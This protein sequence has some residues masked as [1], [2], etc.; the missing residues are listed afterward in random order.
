[1]CVGNVTAK[2][3]GMA[4]KHARKRVWDTEI[5][6][7]RGQQG[8]R[9]LACATETGGPEMVQKWSENW[10]LFAT[11][12]S[13]RAVFCGVV[14]AYPASTIWEVILGVYEASRCEKNRVFWT[15]HL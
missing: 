3:D 4:P 5:S 11:M 10:P 2:M 6:E 1:M 15:S 14:T 12:W 7:I 13:N 9:K 8:G